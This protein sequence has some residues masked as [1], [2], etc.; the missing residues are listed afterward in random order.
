ML[1]R[2]I[3]RINIE[4]INIDTRAS[5]RQFPCEFESRREQQTKRRGDTQMDA[6]HQTPSKKAAAGISRGAAVGGGIEVPPGLKGV[7]V[8]DTE[9][10]DVQGDAGFYHY[11]QYSALDLARDSDLESVWFLL[12]EGHL[13]NA[14]ERAAFRAEIAPHTVLHPRT[15]A[16][17][18]AIVAL[19]E[20]WNPLDALRTALSMVGSRTGMQPSHDL[21]HAGL[22]A[23]ALR[24]CAQVPT[25]VAALW[26]LHTGE[27]LIDPDP[28]LGYAA[29]YL[30][31]LTGEDPAPEH[32][33]AIEQYLIST[34][35][36]GFNAST[37]TARVITATGADVASAVVGALGAFSGPLHGGSPARALETIEAIGTPERIDAWVRERIEGGE[38]MMGFG[39]AVYRTEDPRARMLRE[40]AQNLGGEKVA[41]ATQVEAR[42]LE[43]LAELKPGRELHTNVE[44]YA[45]VVMDICRIPQSMFTP[46]F[47]SSRVIGWAANILEQARDPKIIRPSARYVGPPAPAPLPSRESLG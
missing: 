25:I 13:P 30:R 23:D 8:T 40:V 16:L 28:E 47:A 3:D 42:V 5:P 35:D 11:R 36:H 29:N 27:D 38:R 43:L 6:T 2:N 41:F 33:R 37:F 15:R 19:S 12:F 39:H 22:R 17:L 24:I 9:I 34:V 20:P 18:P 46:T 26:R 31:M 32:A 7:I 14:A 44:F 10:G 4:L 1:D 21:D 45:G